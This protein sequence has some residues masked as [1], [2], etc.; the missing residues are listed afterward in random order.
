MEHSFVPSGNQTREWTIPCLYSILPWKLPFA[1]GIFPATFDEP[2][3]LKVVFFFLSDFS[4]DSNASKML[5]GSRDLA[6][7]CE[8]IHLD[9]A[10]RIWSCTDALMASL[11]FLG[12]L[13]GRLAVTLMTLEERRR[14]AMASVAKKHG[15]NWLVPP[16]PRV[17]CL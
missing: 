13:G 4:H 7:C 15:R 3:Y 1:F 10:W 12:L 17:K 14:L 8:M 6:D 16:N 11:L 2:F 5:P 9:H